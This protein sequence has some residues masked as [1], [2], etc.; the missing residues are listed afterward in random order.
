MRRWLV[1]L[2]ALAAAAVGSLVMLFVIVAVQ[3]KVA[4]LV[5]IYAWIP[6]MIYGIRAWALPKLERN[7]EPE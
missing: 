5:I 1:F 4:A 3:Q 7:D 2:V 6:A